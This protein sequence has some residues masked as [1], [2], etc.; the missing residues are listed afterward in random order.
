MSPRRT[1]LLA[2]AGL[3]VTL[4][5]SSGPVAASTVGVSGPVVT[6]EQHP[7]GAAI[8]WSSVAG[9]GARLAVVEAT[10]GTGYRN[11]WFGA[12]YSGARAA[13]LTRGSFA[14][15]RPATPLV[16]T[17]R[18][19]ADAYLARIGSTVSTTRT[20][21]PVLD[22][23]TTGGLTPA[24]LVTWTQTYLARLHDKS[25]RIPILRTYS[26]FW[27]SALADPDAFTRY[28]LWLA[29]GGAAP[30]VTTQLWTGNAAASV[31]GIA[32][33]APMAQVSADDATWAYMQ[34]GTT[35]PPW[36]AAAPGAPLAVKPQAWDGAATITWM[37][38]DEGSSDVTAFHVTAQP[39]PT[40]TPTPT[41]PTT[42]TPSP[43]PSTSPPSP[44]PDP[45]TTSPAP[46]P[47]TTSA[48]PDSSATA[49]ATPT[50]TTDPSP[51]PT[52]T[53]T[54]TAAP[55][56]PSV[57]VT[58]PGDVAQATV[59]GLVDG[60]AYTFT[61]TA[62]NA[63]GVGP[64][65]AT[66]APVTPTASAGSVPRPASA[67]AQRPLYT[68]DCAA[69]TNLIAG[70]HWKRRNLAPGV[71]F[72]EG[73]HRDSRGVVRMHVLWIDITNPHVRFA[74][75]MGHVADRR[76]L[77]SLA[78]QRYLVAATN[79]GYFDLSSGAP[80]NP[81]V[82]GGQPVFGPS[83]TSAAVGIGPDGLLHSAALAATGTV[84]GPNDTLPLAGW[85]P[86]QPL[87]GVNAYSA[88][89]GQHPVPMPSDAVSRLVV[90][91]AVSSGTGRSRS[92]PAK[93]YLLVAR[94]AVAAGW[95]RSLHYG[96]PVSVQVTLTS[97]SRTPLSLAYSVGTHLVVNGVAQPKLS[98]K[99]TERLPARTAIG[100][101]A[102]GRHAVLLVVDNIHGTRVH[103]VEPSQLARMMRQLGATEAFMFDGGG[104]SE[105]VIRPKPGAR[106]S[107]RNHPTDGRERSIPL[108][109]GVFRR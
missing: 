40:P 64:A 97:S 81:V 71:M 3:L 88:R 17:A 53:P 89:W 83:L 7:G 38:G 82:V 80:I 31:P 39:V 57:T 45:T 55:P 73:H 8:D 22:L 66:S 48:S 15:G 63:E 27:R 33:R 14:V 95:L 90:G 107:V 56:P 12:D 102:D 69:P 51:T 30:S 28:P 74:P 37:P 101:T 13:G 87:E 106:L 104:S 103:G 52:P 46:A 43:D 9:S 44:S 108:G 77:S 93:G 76:A 67:P 75:L 36:P 16:S 58:V 2:C 25:G 26:Y 84:T 29:T 79:A 94:G 60:V 49:T 92:A 59:P 35:T 105:M 1:A 68:Q 6:S 61:V 85:N 70:A 10:D 19:Q 32:G 18:Q 47:S 62:Q 86:A 72:A 24:Q 11:P 21:A 42:T 20:L 98:C 41:D 96:D 54:P 99:R 5:V 109:F 78:R 100:W 4:F 50:P 91:G 34:D 23:E 65:S